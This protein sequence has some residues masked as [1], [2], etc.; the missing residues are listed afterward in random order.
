M[1]KETSKSGATTCRPGW[2][3]RQSAGA[4]SLLRPA[5]RFHFALHMETGT[6]FTR[7]FGD[8][9]EGFY[10][11]LCTTLNEIEKLLTSEEGRPLYRQV[12]DRLEELVEQA[13]DIGWGYGDDLGDVVGEIALAVG[14][15]LGT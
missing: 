14:E 15:D 2:S 8:V 11:S 5:P 6:R 9:D 4:T 7:D 13:H 1:R 3:Q 12:R 10:N